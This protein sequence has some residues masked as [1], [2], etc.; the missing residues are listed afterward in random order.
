MRIRIEHV[1][2]LLVQLDQPL[3]KVARLAGFGTEARFFRTFK[4]TTGMTPAEYR[5]KHSVQKQ[6]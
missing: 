3:R 1:K 6:F 2:R 4:S 5:Q